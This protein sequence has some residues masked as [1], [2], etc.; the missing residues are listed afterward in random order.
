MCSFGLWDLAIL[1]TANHEQECFDCASQSI[2]EIHLHKLSLLVGTIRGAAQGAV[3]MTTV[4]SRFAY[5]FMSKILGVTYENQNNNIYRE[6]ER[7]TP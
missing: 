2:R 4:V 3:T 5:L 7:T 1:T 6:N